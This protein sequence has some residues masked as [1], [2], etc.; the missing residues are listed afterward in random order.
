MHAYTSVIE[1]CLE[2]RL[3]VGYVPGFLGAH[4]QG[5]TCDELRANLCEV[6]ATLLEDGEPKS[7]AIH[8]EHPS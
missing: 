2:T 1:D 8:P 3:Y 5:A 4:C 6:I 7:L